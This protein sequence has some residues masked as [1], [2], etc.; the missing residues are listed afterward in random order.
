MAHFFLKK[1]KH[2]VQLM[3]S[4][5]CSKYT[6]SRMRQ[7]AEKHLGPTF[8]ALTERIKT[9]ELVEAKNFIYFVQVY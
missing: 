9:V 7:R 3:H 8:T 5:N 6:F 1:T 2:L 4:I